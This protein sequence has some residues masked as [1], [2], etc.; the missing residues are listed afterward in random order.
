MKFYDTCAALELGDKMFAEPFALSSITLQELENIKISANKDGDVKARARKL[1][2]LLD[3]RENE[4]ACA[5]HI[6]NLELRHIPLDFE[7]TNDTK[8]LSDAC[9]LSLE[10]PVEFITFDLALRQIANVVALG[11]NNLTIDTCYQYTKDDY[12]GYQEIECTSEE[13]ANFYERQDENIFNLRENEY[14]ILSHDE[15]VVDLRVWR[16]GQHQFLNTKDFNS[17]WFGKVRPMTGDIYQKMLFDS[18]HDNQFTVIRGKPGSGKSYIGLAALFDDL[19]HY[20][21]DNIYIICN[22]VAARD[23]ARLGFLPG[24]RRSKLLDSQIGNFLIGKLGDIS[25]V[26][27]LMDAGKL[28][29]IP[30]ADCRGMDISTNSGVY[31]TEAQ[32]SSIDMMKLMVQRIG[33]NCKIVI[34]GDDATQVDLNAYAGENNGLRRLSEVFRGQDFYGEVRLQNCHRSKWAALAEQM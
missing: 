9:E 5:L 8:I 25:V 24:D 27:Q 14:L 30:A 23:F 20:R 32:N 15:E 10:M 28:N 13:L 33:E 7:T 26:E 6:K 17:K 3:E 4:W 34:E 29:L 2:H 12:T 31:I 19:D 21:I 1:L 18:L 22:P 11:F 16:N